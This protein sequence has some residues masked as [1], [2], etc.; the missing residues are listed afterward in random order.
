[1]VQ[2]F[3]VFW[4]FLHLVKGLESV[5]FHLKNANKMAATRAYKMAISWAYRYLFHILNCEIA[6]R[7]RLIPRNIDIDQLIVGISHQT[8]LS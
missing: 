5:L 8:T 1:M 2:K 4:E 3:S 6:L 7:Q